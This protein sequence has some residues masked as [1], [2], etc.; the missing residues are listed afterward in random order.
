[1]RYHYTVECRNKSLRRVKKKKKKK[2]SINIFYLVRSSFLHFSFGA[3]LK[4]NALKILKVTLWI[5][6]C[7]EGPEM[8]CC[9]KNCI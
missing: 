6:N 8:D 4:E 2:N 3:K 5:Q 7:Q 1:M 9:L